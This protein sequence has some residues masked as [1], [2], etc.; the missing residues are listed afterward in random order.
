MKVK[1][2][3]ISDNISVKDMFETSVKPNSIWVVYYNIETFCSLS[4][5]HLHTYFY[6]NKEI[7]Y[8]A[9][10]NIKTLKFEKL[11]FGEGSNLVDVYEKIISLYLGFFGGYLY[12]SFY[13]NS[14]EFDKYVNSFSFYSIK[15][16]FENNTNNNQNLIKNY[17]EPLKNEHYVGGNYNNSS[18]NKKSFLKELSLLKSLN[19]L[20]VKLN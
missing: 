6:S 19:I 16:D 18:V 4:Y 2:L 20:E 11:I 1:K 13:L 12:K 7:P 8:S 15:N 17:L 5:S 3:E 10:P 9:S 14:S